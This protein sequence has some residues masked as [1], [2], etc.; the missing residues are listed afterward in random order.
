MPKLE[1]SP[2]F[3]R[4]PVYGTRCSTVVAIDSD[5]RGLIVERR[6]TPLGEPTGETCFSFETAG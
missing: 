6:Y 1:A 5:G 2:I 3:V 4:G